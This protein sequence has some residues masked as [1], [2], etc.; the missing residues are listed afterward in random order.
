MSYKVTTNLIAPNK[1][2]R[3]QRP[4][5][6]IKGIVIHYLANPNT[7]ANQ[8]RNY[9]DNLKSQKLDGNERYASAHEIIDL[10][11]NIVI[12]VPDNE[13]TFNCGSKTYTNRCLKE[14]GKHPNDYTYGIECCHIDDNGN[15]TKDTYNSLFNRCVELCI[16]YKLNS[17][18][19][20]LHKEVVGWKSCHKFFVLNPDKWVRFK[21]DVQTEINIIKKGV[22]KLDYKQIIQMCTDSPDKWLKAIDTIVQM[23]KDKGDLGDLEIFQFL[24]TL[25]EKIYCKG[26]DLK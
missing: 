17:N 19:L 10:D 18:N 24:P 23:A 8:N 4:L 14:L 20:W 21:K 15:M 22:A 7:S 1:F 3:P 2:S 5:N 9:F 6:K 11:G 26:I 16:K 25:I 13:I 12:C